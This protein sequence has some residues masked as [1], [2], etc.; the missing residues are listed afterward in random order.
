[1]NCKLNREE[2]LL[3]WNFYDSNGDG[4]LDYVEFEPIITRDDIGNATAEDVRKSSQ[5]ALRRPSMIKVI[6]NI[7]MIASDV[8][9]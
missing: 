7:C 3:L 1:M 2:L 4:R 6:F 8:D 5:L 9:V